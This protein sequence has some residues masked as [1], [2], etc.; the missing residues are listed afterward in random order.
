M[1][2]GNSRADCCLHT[3]GLVVDEEATRVLSRFQRLALPCDK[4]IPVYVAEG[5][6]CLIVDLGAWMESHFPVSL[7]P[8]LHLVL[9]A[10]DNGSPLLTGQAMA[11]TL[12]KRSQ[13]A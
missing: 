11:M 13:L 7:T 12:P 10:F 8:S 4:H 2:N 3:A 1:L 6:D 9:V 5:E